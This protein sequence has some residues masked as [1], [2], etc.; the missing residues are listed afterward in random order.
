RLVLAD[1]ITYAIRGGATHVVD[2]A[3]L[4]ASATVALGHAASAAVANDDGLWEA[5]S[6]AAAAAGERVWRL[7]I[8]PEFHDLLKSQSADLRNSH[9][10]EAGAIAAGMF[11][12]EFV[13]GRP[14]VHL[15]IAGSH[16]NENVALRG[17]PRGPLG[18]GARLCYRV[19][20]RLAG[21]GVVA[22]VAD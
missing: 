17:V 15:D 20:E 8:Y 13:E 5:V 10:G 11:I 18:T 3:T 6:A 14:W 21:A 9:Y 7:P 1:A 12:G 19:A 4:T 2:L 16:W 22:V